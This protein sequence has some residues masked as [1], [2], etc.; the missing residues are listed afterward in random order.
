MNAFKKNNSFEKRKAESSKIIE[1]YEDR[2]PII[3]QKDDKSKIDEI[4]KNKFLVPKDF[5]MSQFIF[6]IRKRIKLEPSKALFVTVN[7]MLIKG[8]ESIASVYLNNK[9]EDGFLYVVYSSE[10]TFG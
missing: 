7:N 10:N 9:D 8:S 4:D 2:C 3:V 5:T 1:K 6:V